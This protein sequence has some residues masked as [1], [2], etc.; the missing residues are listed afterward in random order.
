[1]ADGPQPED[2]I[3]GRI[4]RGSD[5]GGHLPCRVDEPGERVVLDRVDELVGVSEV[6]I[7]GGGGDSHDPGSWPDAD[8]IGAAVFRELCARPDEGV[9]QIPVVIR[10]ATRRRSA[11]LTWNV[12]RR[13]HAVAS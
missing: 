12:D 9:A 3:F 11:H 10:R 1:M 6:S 2:G 7:G 13:A 8:C 5:T 4:S